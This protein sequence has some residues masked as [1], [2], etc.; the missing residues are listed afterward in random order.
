MNYWLAEP[1]NLAECAE[2]MFQALREVA[3]SGRETAREQ[4]GLPGWVLH[5]NFDLWRGTAPI[6]ASNHGIWPTGALGSAN[7][8]GNIICIRAIAYFCGKRPIR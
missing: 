6:N 7:T 8:Y 5:H 3:E 4:Y 2:P 1:C